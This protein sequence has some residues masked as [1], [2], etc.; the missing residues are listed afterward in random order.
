[1]LGS[2][3]LLNPSHLVEMTA[4]RLLVAKR[5]HARQVADDA[6]PAPP[7]RLVRPVRALERRDHRASLPRLE[8]GTLLGQPR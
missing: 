3:D 8:A 7:V 4:K 2:A 6:Q 1:M 5:R